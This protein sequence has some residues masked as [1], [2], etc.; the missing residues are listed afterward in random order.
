VTKRA[1]DKGASPLRFVRG[2]GRRKQETRR[3]SGRLD[4]EARGKRKE[5]IVAFLEARAGDLSKMADFIFDHPE[6]GLQEVRACAL[7]S[8]RLEAMG[9]EVERGY[10][11]LPTAFRG[12]HRNGE[13]GPRIG[14]LCEYDA[15]PGLGHACAHHMQ[16]PAVLGAALALKELVRDRSYTL[17]VIGTPAEETARGGK[18]IMLEGGA[19]RDLDVAL[20]MHGAPQ[21]TTDVR[22]L[23]LSEFLVTFRGVAAHTA[24]APERGRSALDALTLASTGIAFLRGH[25]RDDT[26]M[27]LIVELGGVAVNAVTA[28][29][30][31]R[32]EIRSY[33]RPYLDDLIGRVMRVFEGAAL[34]TDTTWEAERVVDL[35]NKIPVR[36]LNDLLL[37]NAELAGCERF[38]P[39]RERTGST[40]FASVM[41]FVPGS[42]IRVAFVPAGSPAHS[43]VYLDNGKT[44]A[45]HRAVLR[46]AQVLAMT[47][48]DLIGDEEVL[49]EV[50]EEF[51]REKERIS[52]K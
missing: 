17:E 29:A 8:D 49:R 1:R 50:R 44:E 52:P 35:H 5:E 37:R 36:S 18:T 43:R 45:A 32:V 27:N 16:G 24:I 19:F 21:T 33:D 23:A 40:D 47:A 9:F 30:R 11:G 20:M 7:L 13:G 28:E 4:A 34:M 39:P 10:A 12:I 51:T 25:V 14:L 46:G 31:G 22:S 2:G 6:V 42:C 26:R 15:V 48:L 41:Y 38:E 3:E